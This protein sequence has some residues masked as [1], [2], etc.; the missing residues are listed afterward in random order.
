MTSRMSN[1]VRQLQSMTSPIR[2]GSGED[3]KEQELREEGKTAEA[4]GATAIPRREGYS[5][6]PS[7]T[8]SAPRHGGASTGEADAEQEIR[9]ILR[10]IAN[11]ESSMYPGGGSGPGRARSGGT[12]KRRTKKSANKK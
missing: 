5:L 8:K 6:A 10:D 11:L 1:L 9:A 7:T 12:R 3:S 4:A 2:S